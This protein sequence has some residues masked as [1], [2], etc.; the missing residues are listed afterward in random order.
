ML[1]PQ[2]VLT[3]IYIYTLSV[4]Y[5]LFF[6]LEVHNLAFLHV[7]DFIGFFKKYLV[8]PKTTKTV[9]FYWFN[10]RSFGGHVGFVSIFLCSIFLCREAFILE[11]GFTVCDTQSC[12]SNPINVW[13]KS[14]NLESTPWKYGVQKAYVAKI[15]WCHMNIDITIAMACQL[16]CIF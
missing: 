12:K 6:G 2:P 11:C 9:N 16:P 7:H 15:F 3:N 10:A 8:F 14:S 13:K 5:L 1:I 4:V